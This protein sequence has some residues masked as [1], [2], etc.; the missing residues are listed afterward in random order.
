MCECG[1]A[2]ES[3]H[4]SVMFLQCVSKKGAVHSWTHDF[5]R[6]TGN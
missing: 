3:G 5:L 4:L 1:H 2:G 6:F